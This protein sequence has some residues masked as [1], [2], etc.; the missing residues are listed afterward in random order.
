M[1]PL[2]IALSL[3]RWD[4][5]QIIAREYGLYQERKKVLKA[6]AAKRLGQKIPQRAASRKLI[7]SLSEAQ[8]AILALLVQEGGSAQPFDLI[9]PLVL[10]NLVHLPTT[11]DEKKRTGL[12]LLATEIQALLVQGL[13]LNINNSY[14]SSLRTFSPLGKLVIPAE[15]LRVLPRDLLSIPT[16]DLSKYS[17]RPPAR[18]VAADPEDF[19]RQI[20]FVWAELRREPGTARKTGG[21]YKRDVS[22]IAR[23]MG[24]ELTVEKEAEIREAVAFLSWMRLVHDQGKAI[25]VPESMATGTF[26]RQKPTAQL[27][28]VLDTIAGHGLS[29]ALDLRAVNATQWGYYN[30][31]DP[32]SPA[33]LFKRVVEFLEELA[34]VGWVPFSTSLTLLNGGQSGHF[35]FSVEAVRRLF[36][37]AAQ[38][39]WRGSGTERETELKQSLVQLEQELLR[40]L[41]DR[42]H[43]IGVVELGYSQ[44]ESAL[45]SAWHLSPLAAA[46]FAQRP[47]VG[48]EE[49]G[50]IVLQPDFHLLAMGPVSLKTLAEI[51]QLAERE[52]IQPAAISY[53][54]TK[55]SIYRAL[56]GGQT[57]RGIISYLEAVTS[58]PMSQNV[59]RSLQEWGAQHERIVI[60]RDVLVVQVDRAEL[61]TALLALPRLA[62]ILHPVDDCTV[63]L[64]SRYA[65][66]IKRALRDQEILPALSQGPEEDLPRSLHWQDETLHSRAPLPSL[67]VTGSICRV[68]ERTESGWRLTPESVRA[69][70]T[71][72][73][74]VP[75]ICELL[76][77]MTGA[78]LS[79]AWEQRLK[80]WGNHFG[81]AQTA[82]VRLLHLQNAATLAELRRADHGLSR[83]LRPLHKQESDVAV[84]QEKNW[85]QVCER[86]AE[87]GVGI[88]EG[89]WW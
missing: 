22:R 75:E 76:T 35:V 54:V 43:E 47:Y 74:S 1:E 73:Q 4:D 68:A 15:V 31:P 33:Y 20:F 69:A 36:R 10:G 16:P 9:K 30:T 84:V 86:L 40:H 21:L 7:G 85:E 79:T 81:G 3:Y 44:Q 37:N 23:S 77:Q 57:V 83:W 89:R 53:R 11:G 55:G 38:Y 2:P 6:W 29:L 42:L 26:W 27:R 13:V 5:L 78:Q 62:K 46:L 24:V 49:S 41:F 32:Y 72:G 19:L 63:W 28:K 64:Y 39:S 50:Q 12:P 14:G 65:K 59:R 66:R 71:A 34:G 67:Y 48:P 60:H 82:Q 56:Q 80:A 87:W 52:K 8:R 17:C 88:E 70:V 58:Q 45:P 18:A 51:E 61:L 25:V